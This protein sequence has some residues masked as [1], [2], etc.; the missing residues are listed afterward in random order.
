[1]EDKVICVMKSPMP[2][3][4]QGCLN[5]ESKIEDKVEFVASTVS[6]G[7]KPFELYLS[8]LCNG[9]FTGDMKYQTV[10]GYEMWEKLF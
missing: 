5:D 9:V 2:Q 10:D 3:D 8:P 6:D 1:M 7:G 4:I